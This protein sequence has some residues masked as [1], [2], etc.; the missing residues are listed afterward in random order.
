MRP[1]HVYVRW[2]VIWNTGQ[3]ISCLFLPSCE[4]FSASFILFW[5]SR[6][7]SS[8][9]SKPS[10][11]GLRLHAVLTGGMMELM[12][13]RVVYVGAKWLSQTVRFLSSRVVVGE[14]HWRIQFVALGVDCQAK[15]PNGLRI[16]TSTSNHCSVSHYRG[17]SSGNH[18]QPNI[19]CAKDALVYVRRIRLIDSY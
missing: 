5:N 2:C 11:G 13:S 3:T 17:Q 12:R 7:V 14:V 10:G 8:M 16:V 15:P 9:S 6:R 4:A 1:S 19:S 18:D